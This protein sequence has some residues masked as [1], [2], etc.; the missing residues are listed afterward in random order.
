MILQS[1]FIIIVPLLEIYQIVSYLQSLKVLVI[2]VDPRRSTDVVMKSPEKLMMNLVVF[3]QF[4]VGP[5][6]T[7]AD[8]V[9]RG[10]YVRYAV[11]FC[12]RRKVWMRLSR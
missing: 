9:R 5:P 4:V 6:L 2:Q 8:E 10:V 3:Y 7:D 11:T 12:Q 1:Y